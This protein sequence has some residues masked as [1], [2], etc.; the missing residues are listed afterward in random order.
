MFTLSMSANSSF[1][2]NDAVVFGSCFTAWTTVPCPII[3]V[4]ICTR[5]VVSEYVLYHSTSEVWN[6]KQ[7]INSLPQST[8]AY[9]R[10]Y[11][12]LNMSV[13]TLSVRFM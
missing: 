12:E 11:I 10:S 7:I 4:E 13:I 9:G 1:R 5:L 8:S 2:K 6:S 3:D